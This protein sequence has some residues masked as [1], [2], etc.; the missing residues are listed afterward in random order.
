MQEIDRR[1]TGGSPANVMK[2]IAGISFP[3]AKNDILAKARENGAPQEVMDI[4]EKM[5]DQEFGGP[6]DILKAFGEVK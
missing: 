1:V 6:Q 5:P 4:L 3:A 2:Q